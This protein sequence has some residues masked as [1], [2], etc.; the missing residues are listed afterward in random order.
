MDSDLRRNRMTKCSDLVARLARVSRWLWYFSNARRARE[1]YC[2]ARPFWD[3]RALK[4][5]L[6]SLYLERYL[7]LQCYRAVADLSDSELDRLMAQAIQDSRDL[8]ATLGYFAPDITLERGTPL[9]D[10]TRSLTLR[11]LI[12]P[13]WAYEN[14]RVDPAVLNTG[15]SREWRGFCGSGSNSAFS[16]V[17][18]AQAAIKSGAISPGRT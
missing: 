2:L 1:C 6:R 15:A 8:L 16:H 14:L 3:A 17:G 7:A 11:V 10:R 13:M 12:R 18:R 4:S 5:A 9:P